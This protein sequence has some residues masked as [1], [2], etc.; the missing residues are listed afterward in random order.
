[1]PEN[2]RKQSRNI[3]WL[4]L[5][6]G[7]LNILGWS[8]GIE[9]LKRPWTGIAAMNP[10]SAFTFILCAIALLIFE[11]RNQVSFLRLYKVLAFAVIAI[12][13]IRITYEFLEYENGIN[14]SSFLNLIKTPFV[15]KLFFKMAVSTAVKFVLAGIALLSLDFTIKKRF[16]PAQQLGLLIGIVSLI[17]VLGYFYNVP[18]YYGTLLYP[19]IALYT[20]VCFVLLSLA[21]LLANTRVGFMNE[22]TGTYTGALIAKRF[23][24]LAIIVPL[25]LGFIRLKFQYLANSSIELATAI[26]TTSIIFIFVYLIWIY[27]RMLNR[28]DALKS[29]SDLSL[30]KSQARSQAILNAAPDGMI[31]ISSDHRIRFMNQRIQCLFG[32]TE[33]ELINQP[34][35]LL[36][37][38]H[39]YP[40][41]FN[42]ISQAE[43]ESAGHIPPTGIEL[44]AKRKNGTTFPAE[45][46]LFHFQDDEEKM[47]S[48]SVRDITSR[49]MNDEKLRQF[50]FILERTSDGVIF[51]DENFAI[52]SW[53]KGAE[54]IFGHAEKDVLG[55]D[56]SATVRATKDEDIT[57]HRKQRVAAEG[58]IEFNSVCKTSSDELRH[59]RVLTAKITNADGSPKGYISLVNDISQQIQQEQNLIQFNK[60]LGEQVE[61]KTREIKRSEENYRMLVEQAS[62]GIFITDS[63]FHFIDVNTRGCEI[64]GYSRE[65]ILKLKSTEFLFIDVN[66]GE[67]VYADDDND[68]HVS[69]CKF[70]RKDQTEIVLEINSK[71]LSDGRFLGIVR[72]VT[73]RIAAQNELLHSREQLRQLT[74]HLESVREEEGTRIAREIHD[75][76][77]QEL[78]GI[79]MDLSLLKKDVAS[80]IPFRPGNIDEIISMVDGTIK[81]VRKISSELRPTLLDDLGLIAAIDWQL[82][83]FAKRYFIRS[84]FECNIDDI[85]PEASTKTAIFRIFQESLTNIA[86]HANASI[87]HCVVRMEEGFLYLEVSDNGIGFTVRSSSKRK[88][89]GMLGMNERAIMMNGELLIESTPGKG[90]KVSLKVPMPLN[91]LVHD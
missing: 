13:T 40:E 39:F 56:I 58:I 60:Q 75:E 90:T 18:E 11:K 23:I 77:G 64:L 68:H 12:G 44:T 37:Q 41:N 36:F 63:Q 25:I 35:E 88:S 9:I 69:E 29:V 50:A 22:F 82:K 30:R 78:T 76:L 28:R 84:H 21:I 85:R 32:Y 62:D 83:E 8:F 24:P 79:K 33:A 91:I 27:V 73:D 3:I 6:I 43:N 57:R 17:P 59:I 53:N 19:S 54:N 10:V 4:I 15:D 42:N 72:D 48:V 45:I 31:L 16:V 1:M 51:T 66:I 55:R 65:E 67:G 74:R 86:R 26:Y 49:K 34:S 14:R 70:L 7:T 52:Q 20:A 71:F 80:Q 46:T 2:L 5:L 38:Y 89:L 81:T 47:L 87:V 61:S